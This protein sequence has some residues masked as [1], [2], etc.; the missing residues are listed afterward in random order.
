MDPVGVSFGG[1]GVPLLN[2]FVGFRG[3][4]GL[5]IQDFLGKGEHL[6]NEV[7]VP[8]VLKDIWVILSRSFK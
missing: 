2:H 5:V 4:C 1:G 6:F 7:L 8:G 3:E